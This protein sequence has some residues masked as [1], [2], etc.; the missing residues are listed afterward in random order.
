MVLRDCASVAVRLHEKHKLFRTV[1]LR[2][3]TYREL[4]HAIQLAQCLRLS[5]T[6]CLK[7]EVFRI[8][9]RSRLTPEEERAGDT[10]ERVVQLW[11]EEVTE[12]HDGRT[13][14]RDKSNVSHQPTGTPKL[15][16]K[17]C[18]CLRLERRSSCCPSVERR[19]V[20]RQ[21]ERR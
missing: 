4:W 6:Q 3:M 2:A 18:L 15:P 20:C 1:L 21:D 10:S 14:I 9:Q 12:K 8:S 16:R 11:Q 7:D 13:C 19:T 5:L 17:M